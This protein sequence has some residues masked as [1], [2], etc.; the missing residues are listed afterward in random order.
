MP[1]TDDIRLDPIDTGIAVGSID[2][3]LASRIGFETA[4][5]TGRQHIVGCTRR[6]KTIMSGRDSG[7][8]PVALLEFK[9]ERDRSGILPIT[10]LVDEVSDFHKWPQC[11]LIAN[12]DRG[13]PGCRH[14]PFVRDVAL[15]GGKA[16]NSDPACGTRH[17]VVSVQCAVDISERERLWQIGVA[18]TGILPIELASI[19]K[20]RAAEHARIGREHG[21][22]CRLLHRQG[23]AIAPDG[24]LRQEELPPG[25][26]A[27]LTS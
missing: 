25:P 18:D 2:Q 24:V 22:V 10:V 15:E 13:L 23:I 27:P 16:A 11:S 6:A 5:Q 17:F 20:Q 19:R 3:K 12:I 26:S 9:A 14:A 4:S 8:N 21:G 7:C 1:E